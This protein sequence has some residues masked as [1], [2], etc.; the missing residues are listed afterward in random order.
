MRLAGTARKLVA[1]LGNS[2]GKRTGT[3]VGSIN[4]TLFAFLSFPAAPPLAPVNEQR[5]DRLSRVV[6]RKQNH[7]L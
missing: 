2:A 4:G 7:M 5:S 3:I 1:V 6:C